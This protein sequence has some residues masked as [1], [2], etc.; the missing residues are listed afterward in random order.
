MNM[1][2]DPKMLAAMANQK[3]AK[4]PYD[5]F[6]RMGFIGIFLLLGIG[7]V[8]GLSLIHISEPTRPY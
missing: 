4:E 2:L 8:W 3:P 6:L 7:L 1:Q 5:R